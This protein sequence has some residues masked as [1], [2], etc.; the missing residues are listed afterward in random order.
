MM[1]RILMPVVLVLMVG[2]SILLAFQTP[3]F[4]FD[5]ALYRRMAE[6]MKTSHRYFE[7]TWDGRAFY[8]KPPTYL[9]TIVISSRLVDGD[10]PG[11]SIVASR[12]PSLLFS[13]LTV[14]L[15]SLFWHRWAPVYASGFGVPVQRGRGMLPAIAFGTAL[16][17]M[18]QVTSVM[19]DPMLTFFLTIVLLIFSAAL[20]RRD[21]DG[22]RLSTTETVIAAVAMAAAMAV[23]GLIGIVLP[24]LAIVTHEIASA[25]VD[26]E[27]RRRFWRRLMESISRVMPAF[28]LATLLAGAIFAFFYLTIG[29]AFLYEFLIRQHFLRGARALQGHHGPIFYYV[30]ILF[31][32]GPAVAFTCSALLAK[33]KS[34]L[35]FRRWGF[36]LSWS[37]ALIVFISL[38]ATKLPN[39]TWPVWP[40]VA[41]SLC[42][43]IM[44]ASATTPGDETTGIRWL[45]R[46]IDVVAIGAT[47]GLALATMAMSLGLDVFIER[48]MTSLR[49]RTLMTSIEPWP[50][51]VRLGLG[52]IAIAFALQVVGQRVFL[53]K[54]RAG[55][56]GAWSVVAT[57]AALNCAVL[58]IASVAVVPF[59]DQAIRG[60]LMRVSQAASRQHIIGGDLTTIALFSPTVSSYYDG[61]RITQVGASGAFPAHADSQH[62]VLA[63][64]WQSAACRQPGFV[65]TDADKYLL[66]CRNSSANRQA[67]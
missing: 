37:I 24:A 61:G 43:L 19:L 64:I 59:F 6:E 9:W 26:P 50:L 18:V 3:T 53:R 16:F 2:T 47:G 31:L 60:P 32:A 58:L 38:L 42:I 36:P 48:S 34:P 40:A 8:E 27:V 67:Q 57:A 11:I 7:P 30:L 23:K 54:V 51:Q 62:L 5:E 41:L 25:L 17:P 4:D 66:L 22:L 33:R 13:A 15:L 45:R 49:T 39:Y 12:L 29:P 1:P 20:L 55:A 46:G 35:P 28:I 56:A 44:R 21:S 63:P 14:L 10:A 52:L 65:I